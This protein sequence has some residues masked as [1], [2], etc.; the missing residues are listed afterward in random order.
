MRRKD[1]RRPGGSRQTEQI[2]P[3]GTEE[4]FRFGL[5]MAWSQALALEGRSSPEEGVKSIQ[6]VKLSDVNRVARKYLNLD[7]AV[8]S[9]LTP[10]HP[11][12]PSP[13][14]RNRAV[15]SFTPKETGPGKLPDW[16]EKS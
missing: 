15:E 3:S 4:E 16:A 1:S 2:D 7:H 12:S 6:K 9:I 10:S 8:V 14:R 13:L 5:A 11:A